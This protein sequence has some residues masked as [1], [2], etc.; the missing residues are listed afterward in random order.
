[1]KLGPK[2]EIIFKDRY[3]LNED[4]TWEEACKRVAC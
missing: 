1:M 4:E 2:A 3:A